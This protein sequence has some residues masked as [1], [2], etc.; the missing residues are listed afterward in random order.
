MPITLST[1]G[2]DCI[3]VVFRAELGE[4]RKPS[5]GACCSAEGQPAREMFAKRSHE[6]VQRR[7]EED[8][9]SECCLWPPQTLQAA[10]K[11]RRRS[12]LEAVPARGAYEYAC[13]A[14]LRWLGLVACCEAFRRHAQSQSLMHVARTPFRSG[15]PATTA[16]CQRGGGETSADRRKHSLKP[17]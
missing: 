6:D 2:D 17:T 12:A 10:R 16:C 13:I 1:P 11:K 9:S 4:C 8:A 5:K 3:D 14:H 15:A 7:D